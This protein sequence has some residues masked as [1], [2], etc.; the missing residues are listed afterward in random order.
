[1]I[2]VYQS[3]GTTVTPLADGKLYEFLSGGSVGVII[4]CQVT[5]LGGLQLQ[6]AS[7]WI[8]IK[9]RM[10]AIQQETISVTPST[11]GAVNGRLLLHLDVSSDDAPGTWVTQAQTPL[12]ELVQED[13][14]G[15]GTIFEMPLATYQVDQL[16]VTDLQT[17]SPL[18]LGPVSHQ[19]T[20]TYTLDGWTESDEESTANGYPWTQ[21]VQAVPN[22]PF[23]PPVTENSKFNLS[24]GAPHTGVAETDNILRDSLAVIA[25]GITV[26]G[27]GTFTTVVQEKPL[28][29][30]PVVWDIKIGGSNG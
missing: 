7:G 8:L 18:A 5:S 14:N 6:I 16:Q 10:I 4:G 13:I 15:S 27:N 30:I 2:T 24:I 23:A 25:D 19:Y 28:T 12:P 9:G 22:D 1:M 3:D 26:T 21:T 29:D 20:A 17:V 11:S